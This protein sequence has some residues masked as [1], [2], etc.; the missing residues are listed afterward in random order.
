[1]FS[2]TCIFKKFKRFCICLIL[3]I[4]GFSQAFAA[5]L[6]L[7]ELLQKAEAYSPD[8]RLARSDIRLRGLDQ[9]EI[10]SL[11]LPT[12]SLRYDFGHLWSLDRRENVVAIGEG[13]SAS[14]ASTW[15]NSLSMN[16]NL[17]IYDFGDRRY[18][19]AGVQNKIHSAELRY[20][21]MQQQL[22]LSV[23]D[24]FSHGLQT[25]QRV[26]MTSEIAVLSQ[27]AFRASE[28]LLEAGKIGQFQLQEAAMRLAVASTRKEDAEAE[29]IRSLARLSELTGDSY[30]AGEVRFAPL[31]FMA[32][33][34]Q[35]DFNVEDLAGVR[36]F[37][38]ELASLQAERFALQRQMLPSF[39][40][41]GNYRF[42]AADRNSPEKTL[43]ELSERDAAVM[44][45]VNWDFFS[46]G[47]KKIQVERLD[48]QI[49]R[50]TIQRSQRIAELKREISGL[51]QIALL[52]ESGGTHLQRRQEL[53]ETQT[54]ATE[55]MRMEGL[56]DYTAALE[57]EIS[58]LEEFLDAEL[59]RI[60]RQADILRFHFWKQGKDL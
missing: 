31:N 3:L 25:H 36:L 50:L 45:V 54:E 33:E 21:E 2:D 56:L 59:M 34:I 16:A 26:Q 11:W 58:L 40:L 44:L 6:V 39:A 29:K 13:V 5:V 35:G 7:D 57:R 28:R 1:M 8:L 9:R 53:L 18:R 4:S 23:L 49:Q 38:A 14:D 17:L 42:Y 47:R 10:R 12:L 41:S 30:P 46:G 19:M 51:E 27:R 52:Q 22:F 60:R 20:K 15:Q 24:A 32:H 43:G 55:R 37:D 48:E